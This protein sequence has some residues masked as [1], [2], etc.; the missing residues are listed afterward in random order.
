MDPTS[1]PT[2]RLAPDLQVDGIAVLLACALYVL[3]AV[4]VVPVSMRRE[5]SERTAARFALP[6]PTQYGEIRVRLVPLGDAGGIGPHRL[7]GAV[8]DE[9][10]K[11]FKGKVVA[12][13]RHAAQ[14]RPKGEGGES[15]VTSTQGD[16][17]DR[18]RLLHGYLPTATS[19][20]VAAKDIAKPEYPE[21]ARVKGVEGLVVVVA[22]VNES[23]HV[24]DVALEKGVDP[25]LDQ[26]AV[27]AAYRTSFYPYL[28]EG[29]AQA[30]YVRMPYRFELVGTLVE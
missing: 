21:E 18:L 15:V 27:R 24:E 4:V 10:A 8:R 3:L 23:G 6:G 16:A 26:A 20:E 2:S 22:L 13:A 17:L 12:A 29:V 7:M 30:V 11:D 25:L 19:S 14:H 5:S 28:L 9:T 1:R